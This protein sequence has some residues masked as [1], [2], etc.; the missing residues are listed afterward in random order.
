MA[1]M[2]VYL[3]GGAVRDELLGRQ[4]AERD[5]VVVG[6]SA[7]QMQRLGFRPV[8]RDFPVFL[9]PDTNEEYALAR[10]ER[11]T[12]PGYRGFETRAA[13]EVTL[14]Q[15]LQ[16]RD[17]TIN[18]MARSE[19]GL[20]ID[21][22]GG[23]ADLDARLLRH[24]SPA[25]VEDPVRI[26]RVARFAARFAS[27]GFHV[28]PETQALM[29]A[30][31]ENGEIAALVPERVWR[32]MER[33]LAGESA[34]EAVLRHAAGS[35]GALHAILPE[36]EWLASDRTAPGSA[37]HLKPPG[38]RTPRCSELA[39]AGPERV[40]ACCQ[41]LRVPTLV[42]DL[43]LLCARLAPRVAQATRLDAPA[44]L[45]LLESADAL[46]RP[47]R[48]SELLLRLRGAFGLPGRDRVAAAG[49]QRG[50]RRRTAARAARRAGRPWYCAG[51]ARRAAA[52]AGA[53]ASGSQRWTQILVAKTLQPAIEP[54]RQRDRLEMLTHLLGQQQLPGLGRQPRPLHSVGRRGEQSLDTAAEQESGLGAVA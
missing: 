39:G 21:P 9:H 49:T 24:V 26:L 12:A 52:A 33:A 19:T 8:G 17:L 31:V 46:R 22:Y 45:E 3:V 30:M 13:P 54:A 23:R 43:A 1:A 4:P 41:R 10:V 36:L 44:L 27:L 11:K 28:A 5:W 18:A 51:A 2:Q 37:R 15:D 42:R 16:R 34:P 38:L 47:E 20:L 32:E 35:L 7:E 25:F 6:A 40:R 14:E 29:R 48:F 50:R 53:A